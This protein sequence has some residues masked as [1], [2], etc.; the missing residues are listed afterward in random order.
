MREGEREG[1][2]EREREREEE[3]HGQK[4]DSNVQKKGREKRKRL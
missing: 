1:T 2:R 4:R 3:M